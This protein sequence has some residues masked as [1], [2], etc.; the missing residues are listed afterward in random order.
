MLLY[1]PLDGADRKTENRPD[2]ITI[3]HNVAVVGQRL[4]W[5]WCVS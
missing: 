1:Y 5:D 2:A 4:D 3:K